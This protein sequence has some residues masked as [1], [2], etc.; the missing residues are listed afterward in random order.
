MVLAGA[1]FRCATV[2]IDP[3]PNCAIDFASCQVRVHDTDNTVRHRR[4][5]LRHATEQRVQTRKL[6]R[7]ERTSTPGL[8]RVSMPARSHPDGTINVQDDGEA[9]VTYRFTSPSKVAAY[10]E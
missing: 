3:A 5:H 1:V 9:S 4:S 6:C 2:C 10:R 7:D 8:C